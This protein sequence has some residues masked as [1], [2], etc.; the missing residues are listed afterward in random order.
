MVTHSLERGVLVLTL[1]DA[2]GSQDEDDIPGRISDLV[3]AH[4]PRPVVIVLG[5]NPPAAATSAVLRAHRMCGDLG[6]PMS[7]ATHSAPVRRRLQTQAP[8]LGARLVVH[9]RTDTAIATAVTIA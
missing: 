2:P 1:D 7:V 5:G 9:A 3:H 8:V 6:V 4:D